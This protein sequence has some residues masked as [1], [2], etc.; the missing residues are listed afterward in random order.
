MTSILK[1]FIL[2]KK[3]VFEQLLNIVNI[4]ILEI[5]DFFAIH[6]KLFERKSK[7]LKSGSYGGY[8]MLKMASEFN[9]AITNKSSELLEKI[10]NM[11]EESGRNLSDEQYDTLISNCS[12][13]FSTIIDNYHKVF[14][15]EFELNRTIETSLNC[16]KGNTMHKISCHIKA[17]KILTRTKLDKALLWTKISTIF[18]GISLLLSIIAIVVTIFFS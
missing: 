14:Q 15:K 17:L 2:M 12:N 6:N 3:K 7:Q 1:G 11:F 13:T 5:H 18:A 10:T 8:D 16:L 9:Q 4:E